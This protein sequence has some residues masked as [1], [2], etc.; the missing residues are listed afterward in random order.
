VFSL[1]RFNECGWR[2]GINL[3]SDRALKPSETAA[4]VE[5]REKHGKFKSI[6]DLKKVSGIDAAEI[7]SKKDR[8]AFEE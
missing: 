3:G 5:Y 6:A 7:E 2:L 1:I 4:T 8:F